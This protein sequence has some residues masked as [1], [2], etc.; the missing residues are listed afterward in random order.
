MTQQPFDG[1]EDMI[2][3]G[4]MYAGYAPR[5]VS[6][7]RWSPIKFGWTQDWATL[8]KRID[9]HDKR[10]FRVI[11]HWQATIAQEARFHEQWAALRVIR[12]GT[13]ASY[14]RETYYPAAHLISRV[15]DSLSSLEVDGLASPVPG[16]TMADVYA[17]LDSI[18]AAYEAGRNESNWWEMP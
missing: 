2:L 6:A 11:V 17:Q 4:L 8:K 14:R 15:I 3:P 12:G 18:S 1:L 9:A 16:W 7:Y 13:A 5:E 10:G